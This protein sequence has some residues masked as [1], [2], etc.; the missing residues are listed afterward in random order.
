[1]E[2]T[3][4]ITLIAN[5][6]CFTKQILQMDILDIHTCLMFELRNYPNQLVQTNQFTIY[7]PQTTKSIYE[8]KSLQL[9]A[10]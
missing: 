3:P 10:L 4:D 2:F 7:K 6:T 8:K 9:P 5:N 1:M